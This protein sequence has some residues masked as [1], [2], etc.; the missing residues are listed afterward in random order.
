MTHFFVLSLFTD[1]SARLPN[2]SDIPSTK[3]VLPAPV[4]PVITEKPELNEIFNSSI[5]T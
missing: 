4:S 2:N 1:K 3:I 5:N